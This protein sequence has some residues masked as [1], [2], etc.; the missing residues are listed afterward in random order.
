MDIEMHLLNLNGIEIYFL[1]QNGILVSNC[2]Y[3]GIEIHFD[4][5]SNLLYL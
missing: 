2:V 3:F 4:N 5:T 1:Y